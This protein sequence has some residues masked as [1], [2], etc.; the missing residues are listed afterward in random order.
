MK[1]FTNFLK[2]IAIAA[3]I[4]IAAFAPAK[5][6]AQQS[7][8][9]TKWARQ[10]RDDDSRMMR[11]AWDIV[12][13][14]VYEFGTSNFTYYYIFFCTDRETRQLMP[15]MGLQ[16]NVPVEQLEGTYRQSGNTINLTNSDRSTMALSINADGRL[17]SSDGRTVYTKVPSLSVPDF[18]DS[19]KR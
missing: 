10:M 14:E 18:P 1:T 12:T 19:L 7:V 13:F 5:I 8:N 9:N 16:H 2:V 17:T 15:L 4:G 11:D 6:H 3:V